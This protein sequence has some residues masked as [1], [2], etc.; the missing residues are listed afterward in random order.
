MTNLFAYFTSKKAP[1]YFPD[2]SYLLAAILTIAAGL[3]AYRV[4]IR[5]KGLKSYVAKT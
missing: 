2:I 3:V 1:V 4:L 5:E